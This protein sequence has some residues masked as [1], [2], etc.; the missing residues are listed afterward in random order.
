M[1]RHQTGREVLRSLDPAP[2]RYAERHGLRAA[3]AFRW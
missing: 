1:D 3:Y 2:A